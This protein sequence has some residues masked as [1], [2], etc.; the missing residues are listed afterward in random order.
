[1]KP[2]LIAFSLSGCLGLSA[3][4]S[5]GERPNVL[6]ISID[7]LRPEIGAYGA[8]HMHTPHM[9]RLAG[10]GLLFERAYVNSPVCGASRA[11]LMTGIYPNP[12]DNTAWDA[13]ADRVE[14][15]V[16]TLPE[17]FKKQWLP[18]R[19]PRQDDASPG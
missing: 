8:A 1:M 17:Y 4:G 14:P 16:T 5:T 2:L 7:D 11:S 15:E 18:H 12:R 9:D 19:Q 6:F 13:R 10:E 3:M